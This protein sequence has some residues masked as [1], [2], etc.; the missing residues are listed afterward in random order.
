VVSRTHLT[1]H[2]AVRLGAVAVAAVIVAEGAVWLLR[3]RADSI[4]PATVSEQAY[5]SPAE[6]ERASDFRD[7]QRLIGLAGLAV[8]GGVLVG[9]ALWRPPALRRALRVASRRPILGGAAVGAGIALTLAVAGLPLGAVAHSRARDVGLSTQTFAAWLGDQGRA[10]GIAAVLAGIGGAGAIALSRRLG[11]RFWIGG[12]VLVV[13]GAVVLI[14][15]APVVLAP[16]FNRFEPLPDGRTRS[17]VLALADRAGVSVGEVYRVDASR[18]STALNAYVDGI[19]TTKRVV[20]Y[21]NALEELR[22]GELN[23]VV[24]HELAHVEEDDI[25]RG[26]AFLALVAPLG[27]LFAQ[28][29]AQELTRRSG[30]DIRTPAGL[31]ALALTAAVAALILGVPG[32]QLSRA[33][34]SRADTFALELTRDPSALIDLQK[35]LAVTNVGDPDPPSVL[36]FLFGTHP[37]TMERIGA[38]VTYHRGDRTAAG[39]HPAPGG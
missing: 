27:V 20:I 5:F 17:D 6:L 18:R 4:P 36:H 30:D 7:T 11:R 12:S 32:N 33:V 19:G 25:L 35:R 13:V 38:A 39:S 14:W 2:G 10:A 8:E 28:L 1:R 31:P 22:P 26:L 21:D 24:A 9:L 34:E 29:S 23:S 37:T 15:L 3:P 16:I